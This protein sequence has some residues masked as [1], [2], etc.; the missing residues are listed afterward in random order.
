[1]Q[2][3]TDFSK[4]EQTVGDTSYQLPIC[5]VKTQVIV[6]SLQV[7]ECQFDVSVELAVAK[8]IAISFGDAVVTNHK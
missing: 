4:C 3:A 8:P 6:K 7:L 2:S 5:N 1:M